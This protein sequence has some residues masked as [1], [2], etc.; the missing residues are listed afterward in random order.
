MSNHLENRA[1]L[2]KTKELCQ[3]ILD[4]PE[5]AAAL[6]RVS[7][8]IADDTARTQYEEVMAQNQELHRKH[9]EG[10]APSQDEIDRFETSRQRLMGNPVAKGFLDAQE[11]MRQ[12]HQTVSD[13]V[14]KTFELGRVPELDDFHEGCCG[15]GGG[16]GGHECGCGH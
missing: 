7:T 1:V 4:E 12:I 16:G 3:V 14:S 13:Y 6:Q 8:F 5:L 11:E 15:G 2:G 9:H 10:V